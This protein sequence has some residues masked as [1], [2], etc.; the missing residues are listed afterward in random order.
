MI[1]A[2]VLLACI[3]GLAFAAAAWRAID[4]VEDQ[5]IDRRLAQTADQLERRLSVGQM[6]DLPPSVTLYR[7]DAMP[8]TLR[9]LAAGRHELMLDGNSVNV[10]ARR[11]G[12]SSFVLV[13][14]DA[15]FE[16]IK[17]ELYGL[18]MAAFVGCLGLAWAFGRT[19][20]SQ[21]IAP[22]TA[23]ARAVEQDQLPDA[24]ALLQS[25]DELGVLARAFASRTRDLQQGLLREQHFVADVSHELRTPLT[26]I[27]GAAEILHSRAAADPEFAT[28]VDRI[29]RT[30][31]D[32]AARVAALLLL[33]RK[34]EAIEA[35]DTALAPLIRIEMERCQ[36]LLDGKNV[37]LRF[38]L[39]ADVHVQ[40]APELVGTA[41]GNLI[42]NACR[43]TEEGSVTVRLERNRLVVEDTGIGIPEALRQQVFDR[44][45][46][47]D[48]GHSGGSGGAGL[49]L[50]IVRR[51]AQHLAWQVALEPTFRPGSR[52]TLTWQPQPDPAPWSDPGVKKV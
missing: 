22:V 52:F 38:D 18:L 28:L 9:G 47:A 15:D 5:L 45:V 8:P 41:I 32:T 4:G 37:A 17:R 14:A 50:A 20:A 39:A 21:V 40:A 10:L 7:G 34:P 3:V 33:S 36:P 48:L 46:R 29:R 6:L 51:V 16:A 2:H 26:V 35:P 25:G 24:F 11:A 1:S 43:Y 23:L 27:I 19:T 44:H 12:A 42:S 30:A 49:G 13:D 31:A